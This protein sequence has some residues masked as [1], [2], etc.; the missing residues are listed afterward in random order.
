MNG[1]TDLATLP[2][3][4]EPELSDTE[5]VFRT[6][7]H[8]DRADVRRLAPIGVFQEREGTSLIIRRSHAEE[9]C[10]PFDAVMRAI[11]L[12]VHSS[13]AA[14]GF[15]AAVATRLALHGISAN[16]AAARFH[17]HVF[18]PASDAERALGILRAPRAEA[19]SGHG[20]IAA[21]RPDGG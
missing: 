21:S 11:T 5:V 8:A 18:V 7:P 17:D 1:A 20:A 19:S 2:A 12:N 16:V 13:L 3:T 4:M 14:V 6:I 9:H 15:T 10:M